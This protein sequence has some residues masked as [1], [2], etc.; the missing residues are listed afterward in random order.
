ME[1]LRVCEDIVR[2]HYAKPQL[3]R[4]LRSLRHGI[5]RAV[6]ALPI[7][8]TELLRARD[9]RHDVGKRA[10]AS[11]VASLEQ[12]LLINFQRAKESLRAL[13]ECSRLITVS[14]SRAFQHLRFQAYALEREILLAIVRHR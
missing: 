3:T 7:D 8:V 12:S 6:R 1:G 14:H 5:A 10:A 2:F 4:R 11:S 9:S 13:E